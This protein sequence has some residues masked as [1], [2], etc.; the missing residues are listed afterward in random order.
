M[1]A[2]VLKDLQELFAVA[3]AKTPPDTT[4]LPGNTHLVRDEIYMDAPLRSR[5]LFETGNI[6]DFNKYYEANITPSDMADVFIDTAEGYASTHFDRFVQGKPGWSEDRAVLKLDRTPEFEELDSFVV[7]AHTQREAVD[8]ISDMS[9]F[10]VFTN[11]N[12][13]TV[14]TGLVAQSFSSLKKSD[15]TAITNTIGDFG[16]SGSVLNDVNISSPTD[17]LP[18]YMIVKL[19]TYD[20]FDQHTRIYRISINL[21]NL[22]IR[23]KQVRRHLVV[24]Q[25][26]FE[27][28]R[29]LGAVVPDG[30]MFCG[31]YESTQK[32]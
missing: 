3:H 1:E 12:E 23:F 22:S 26:K 18:T 11:S 7:D 19:A 25:I 32:R 2:K 20:G 10:L 5:G 16:E 31:N 13:E 8:F 24:E 9:P 29:R 27:I 6:N 21:E 28:L 15:D 14:A 30:N 17:N 4:L